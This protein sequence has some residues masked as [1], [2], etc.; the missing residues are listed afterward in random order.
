MAVPGRNRTLPLDQENVMEVHFFRA[1]TTIYVNI[2]VVDKLFLQVNLL[3][4]NYLGY[5][6]MYVLLHS[7]CTTLFQI[8]HLF[9]KLK[10]PKICATS[11]FGNCQC[12]VNFSS[13]SLLLW[14][15]SGGVSPGRVALWS[16]GQVT[17]WGIT[18]WVRPLLL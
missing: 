11:S 5:V 18:V 6:Y 12:Q 1:Q 3:S 10:L 4:Q 14:C 16:V 2:F 17:V 7:A 8:T 13:S 15:T 9:V